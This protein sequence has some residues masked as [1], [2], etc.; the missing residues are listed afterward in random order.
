MPNLVVVQAEFFPHAAR[1]VA[2]RVK[3]QRP[4]TFSSKTSSFLTMGIFPVT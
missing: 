1:F 3:P 4:M 2:L